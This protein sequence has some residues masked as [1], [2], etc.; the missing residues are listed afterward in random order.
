MLWKTEKRP[1]GFMILYEDG[2]R[3]ALAV[4]FYFSGTEPPSLL[5]QRSEG[6]INLMYIIPSQ[7]NS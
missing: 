2:S 7:T 1:E 4:A 3:R 6:E 5:E